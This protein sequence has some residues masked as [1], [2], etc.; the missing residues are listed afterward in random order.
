VGGLKTFSKEMGMIGIY[1]A[2]GRVH[3]YEVFVPFLESV[4]DAVLA[5]SKA[6]RI[7]SQKPLGDSGSSVQALDED[8]W[9]DLEVHPE[10]N[11][12]VTHSRFRMLTQ[13]NISDH[14]SPRLE[15]AVPL[16]DGEF[17]W[18]YALVLEQTEVAETITLTLRAKNKNGEQGG[19]DQPA[20]AVKSKF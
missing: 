11:S 5:D 19:A 7:V 15:G 1:S 3:R 12:W 16:S 2:D 9:H 18:T 10:L 6:V 14:S 17:I 20:A 4:S 8:G 13:I